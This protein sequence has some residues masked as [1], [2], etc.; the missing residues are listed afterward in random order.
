LADTAP[1]RELTEPQL[2]LAEHSI[3]GA[4]FASYGYLIRATHTRPSDLFDAPRC[5]PRWRAPQLDA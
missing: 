5:P 1:G 2:T 4:A 3:S